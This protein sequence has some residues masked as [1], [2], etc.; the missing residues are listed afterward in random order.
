MK[1]IINMTA[2]GLGSKPLNVAPVRSENPNR[3][4]PEAISVTDRKLEVI[5]STK[6]HFLEPKSPLSVVQLA[7]IPIEKPTESQLRKFKESNFFPI[8]EKK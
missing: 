3:I 8:P 1:R 4:R 7:R 2:S 6:V 5:F